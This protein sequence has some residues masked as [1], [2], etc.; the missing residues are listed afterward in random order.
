MI[1]ATLA[2]KNVAVRES[3]RLLLGISLVV[4]LP[5]SIGDASFRGG[6]L[7]RLQGRLSLRRTSFLGRRIL[8]LDRSP[9]LNALCNFMALRLAPR[10]PL[11][12]GLRR[13]ATSL[14]SSC[15]GSIALN[16]EKRIC[17]T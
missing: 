10:L 4:L 2:A 6:S 15:G 16:T 9:C 13:R 3:L 11:C 14:A 12:W 1:A 5:V 17:T 8:L 7:S